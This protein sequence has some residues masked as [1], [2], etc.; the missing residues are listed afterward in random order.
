MSVS[1]H[2]C[3]SS[4]CLIG[5]RRGP[6][7]ILNMSHLLVVQSHTLR[8]SMTFDVFRF[9]F[10]LL[11]SIGDPLY[12]LTCICS[13]EI[14]STYKLFFSSN[15]SVIFSVVILSA[16]SSFSKVP[17]LT[18]WFY[19]FVFF[20]VI[21]FSVPNI[22]MLFTIVLHTVLLCFLLLAYSTRLE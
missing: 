4:T 20:F 18:Q 12:P 7:N 17:F 14:P 21:Q 13:T 10:F 5:V 2:A 9:S 6:G 1:K 22:M 19:F 15:F 11:D 8:P 3:P 16:Y